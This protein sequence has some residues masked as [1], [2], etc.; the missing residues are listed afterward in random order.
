MNCDVIC[1]ALFGVSDKIIFTRLTLEELS[2]QFLLFPCFILCFYGAV[3][4]KAVEINLTLISEC[5]Q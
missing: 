5:S 3:E 4:Q 2:W 1:Q